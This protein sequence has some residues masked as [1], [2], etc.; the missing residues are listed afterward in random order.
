MHQEV[1]S[2]LAHVPVSPAHILELAHQIVQRYISRLL[3]LCAVPFLAD[4]ALS[5]QQLPVPS[6]VDPSC[7]R[8]AAHPCQRTCSEATCDAGPQTI[9]SATPIPAG[10]APEHQ[11][12]E[13]RSHRNTIA[14][15]LRS[16]EAVAKHAGGSSY[17]PL[18]CVRPPC[19][20]LPNLRT[21]GAQ[22]VSILPMQDQAD[23][24][25]LQRIGALTNNMRGKHT[26]RHV[27]LLE[28]RQNP[29]SCA[30]TMC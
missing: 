30:L 1:N 2:R 13:Q 29:I 11:C 26:T 5:E 8:Q 25:G 6:T 4:N 17:V 22:D 7:L 16:H 20:W 19:A 18:A 23:R 10:Y 28:V 27:S 3:Y 12:Q 15:D 9:P 21:N 24:L 14:G